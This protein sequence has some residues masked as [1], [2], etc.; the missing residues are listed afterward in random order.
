M[1]RKRSSASAQD[2]RSYYDNVQPHV[3]KEIFYHLTTKRILNILYPPYSTSSVLL[4]LQLL[5]L[6]DKLNQS[7]D[8]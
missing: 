7:N 1:R 5:Y 3:H 4:S 2:I 6:I 8:S